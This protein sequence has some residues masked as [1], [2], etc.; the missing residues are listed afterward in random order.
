MDL[1]ELKS[2]ADAVH[3]WSNC[4]QA[5]LDH[6]ED[7]AAAVVGHIDEDGNTYPVATIDCDQYACGGDSI[8]LAR[9]YA[10][11]NPATVSRLLAL[12]DAGSGVENKSAKSDTMGQAAPPIAW[13]S[14][15]LRDAAA[16]RRRQ[17]EAEGYDPEHDDAH[18]N[19]EIAAMAAYYAMPDGAR[20]WP[21]TETGY[22]Y[23]WGQAIIPH[24]WYMPPPCD[25]RRELV[26]AGAL[27]LAEIERLDRRAAG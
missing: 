13:A 8:K 1:Q 10:A 27:I 24:G 6:V 18:V 4:N 26:K 22:G 14:E 19:D 21:A 17:I 7:E 3:G 12:I 23:T 5:W 15:A 9:F 11:A 25:R 2:L 20:A 16:E